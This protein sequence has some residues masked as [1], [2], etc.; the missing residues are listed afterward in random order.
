MDDKKYERIEAIAFALALIPLLVYSI[1]VTDWK[2]A[3]REMWYV[4]L[5]YMGQGTLYGGQPFCEQ[6]GPFL[7]LPQLIFKKL[8]GNFQI[9]TGIMIAILYIVT[10]FLMT[11]ISKKETGKPNYAFIGL[12]VLAWL[13]PWSSSYNY[14]FGGMILFFGFYILYYSALRFKEI[15]AG[16]LFAVAA[17]VNIAMLMPIFIIAAFYAFRAGLIKIERNESKNIKISIRYK[18][19][20]NIFIIFIPVLLFSILFRLMYPNIFKYMIFAH[21]ESPVFTFWQA[22]KDM[23]PFWYVNQS[24][25]IVYV[26]LVFCFL[27]F[28]KTFSVIPVLGA[29]EF[30]VLLND[31]QHF[32]GLYFGRNHFLT[33][34]FIILTFAIL[35]EKVKRASFERAAL[36]CGLFLVIVYPAIVPLP[37]AH[38]FIDKKLNTG[39]SNFQ[40]EIG[41]GINF[42]PKQDGNILAEYPELLTSY[43]F[44]FDRERLDV[45]SDTEYRINIDEFSG[46]RLAKLGV[47]NLTG[48]S[49]L[50]LDEAKAKANEERLAEIRS[51]MHVK[52]YSMIAIG[53][54]SGAT[55]IAQAFEGMPPGFKSQY[56]RLIVPNME[57]LPVTSIH[58]ATLYLKDIQDCQTT[59]VRM[60]DYYGRIFDRICKKSRFAANNVVNIILGAVGRQKNCDKGGNFV[61]NFNHIAFFPEH[62]AFI[63]GVM[64]LFLI[65]YIPALKKHNKFTKKSRMAYALIIIA[66]IA[67]AAYLVMKSYS[68]YREFLGI[69]GSV[70]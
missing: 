24:V 57:H 51:L 19:I 39:I 35:K 40:K 61:D 47:T 44:D 43:D 13:Y 38:D 1:H 58:I 27:L 7:Y 22:L 8:F 64:A 10:L 53:P 26:A 67:I 41:Y 54:R 59:F 46:P 52:N 48:W 20:L 50:K 68:D 3:Y 63:F 33:F 6:G 32:G 15:I 29:L 42:V 70:G 69:V 21:L 4:C 31:H 37:F 9:L 28:I 14:P 18:K 34:L 23:I 60:V 62:L 65:L 45:A 56:C 17:Y 25:F 49:A 11:R 30:W 16:I 2:N 55:L 5:D 36:Y 12:L 66:M